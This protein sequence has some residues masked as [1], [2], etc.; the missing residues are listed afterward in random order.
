VYTPNSPTVANIEVAPG[1]G[2][3][4]GLIIEGGIY[5]G[6]DSG[7]AGVNAGHIN[8]GNNTVA[9]GI[10]VRGGFVLGAATLVPFIVRTASDGTTVSG[11]QSAPTGGLGATSGV[12]LQAAKECNIS[13]IVLDG[14][15]GGRGIDLAGDS[16]RNIIVGNT[17]KDFDIGIRIQSGVCNDNLVG[18]NNFRLVSSTVGFQDSGANTIHGFNIGT[19]SISPP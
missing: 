10:A 8:I 13:G 5:V 14:D 4:T 15:G 7:T 1:G 2:I 17:L 3:V 19:R 6:P 11:L 12:I 16:D 18:F 9:S